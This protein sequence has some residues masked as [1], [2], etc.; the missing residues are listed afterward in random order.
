[1]RPFDLLPSPLLLLTLLV[2]VQT[3]FLEPRLWEAPGAQA[4]EA[5]QLIVSRGA[6]ACVACVP[7]GPLVRLSAC[8]STTTTA[9]ALSRAST[10]SAY[11]ATPQSRR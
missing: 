3:F 10:A 4:V 2:Q 9:T 7:E 5:V 1:M 11:T 8:R 6:E